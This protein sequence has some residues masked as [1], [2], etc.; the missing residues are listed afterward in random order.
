[1]EL[2][3]SID[4]IYK[5]NLK[6]TIEQKRKLLDKIFLDTLFLLTI[7]DRFSDDK[8]FKWI[9]PMFNIKILPKTNLEKY[10]QII[11]EKLKDDDKKSYF[12]ELRLKV[13]KRKEK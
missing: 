1:L 4:F 8:F 11:I 12:Q 6:L 7:L 3:E 13:G 2:P 10:V 5:F 9:K